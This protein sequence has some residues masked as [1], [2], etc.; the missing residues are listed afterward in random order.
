MWTSSQMATNLAL[1][2]LVG[3]QPGADC[4]RILAIFPLNSH[5]HSAISISLAK[6]LAARGHELDV[7]S[8]YPLKNPPPN[9]RDHSLAGILPDYTNN[10]TYDVAIQ[11]RL[12]LSP[13]S[14]KKAFEPMGTLTCGLMDQPVFKDLREKNPKD[15]PYDL[16]IIEVSY[17]FRNQVYCSRFEIDIVLL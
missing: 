17:E 3:L 2:L 13:I 4:L 12:S 14:M 5:S 15:K 9:Y 8:H 7:Y 11:S 6:G 16:V 1:L 10:M